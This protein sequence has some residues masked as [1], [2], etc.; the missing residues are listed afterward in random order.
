MKQ[1]TQSEGDIVS[2][3]IFSLLLFLFA[4]LC[5]LIP[6]TLVLCHSNNR[7]YFSAELQSRFYIMT[8]FTLFTFFAKDTGCVISSSCNYG[9]YL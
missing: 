6:H 2:T 7:L 4:E 3:W 5:A 1:I 8:S 9:R